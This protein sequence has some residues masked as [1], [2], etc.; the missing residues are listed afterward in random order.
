MWAAM[1]L[2]N[3]GDDRSVEPLMGALSDEDEMVRSEVAFALGRIGDKGA[4]D[5][6]IR[7][8]KGRARATK[9]F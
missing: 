7:A 8:L 2:G 1:G 4:R 3:I 6:L 5:S 9:F